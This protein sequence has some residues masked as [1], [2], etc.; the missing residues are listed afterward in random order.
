MPVCEADPWPLQFFDGIPCP[1]AARVPA[2]DSDGWAWY[3]RQ[4]SVQDKLPS[5]REQPQAVPSSRAFHIPRQR[6]PTRAGSGGLMAIGKAVP[7][8]PS[9]SVSAHPSRVPSAIGIHAFSISRTR[10]RKSRTILIPS[11]VGGLLAGG[12]RGGRRGGR[13]G[14]GGIALPPPVPARKAIRTASRPPP[15][16]MRV[17][18]TRALP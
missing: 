13:E 12:R 11:L 9:M 10:R 18:L 2:D 6:S 7:P 1:E 15:P 16:D 3:P 14:A 8:R 17:D 5:P 4:K